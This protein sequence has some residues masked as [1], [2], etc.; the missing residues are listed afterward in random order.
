MKRVFLLFSI[1]ILGSLPTITKAVVLT[2]PLGTTDVRTVVGTVIKSILGFSGVAA[3][4]MFV[5]GG[6]QW[7]LSSGVPKKVEAGKETL[8][9]AALGLVFIFI[10]YTLLS[11]LLSA[12][13]SVTP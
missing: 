13:S 12:V 4:L 1:F 10:S 2:N 5:Y 11:T 6:V 8:K 7:T 9:W 3:L